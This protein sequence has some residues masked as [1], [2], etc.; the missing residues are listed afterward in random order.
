[1]ASPHRFE[2][3]VTDG[4]VQEGQTGEEGIIHLEN[5]PG[6]QCTLKFFDAPQ[7]S[8]ASP[9]GEVVVSSLGARHRRT[10]EVLRKQEHLQAL[11]PKIHDSL[12]AFT[13]DNAG[14]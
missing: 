4:A 9:C 5:C 2:A 7:C 1:M 12:G 10:D 11:V 14:L 8:C 13:I 6:E 3:Q